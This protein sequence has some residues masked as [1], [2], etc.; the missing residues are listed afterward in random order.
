MLIIHPSACFA[1]FFGPF[2]LEL[3][4]GSF[5]PAAMS[6]LP[7]S[8]ASSHSENRHPRG[9]LRIPLFRCLR[10]QTHR[11]YMYFV[12]RVEIVVRRA[13][14]ARTSK[15]HSTSLFFPHSFSLFLFFPF[16]FFLELQFT[17]I[18]IQTEGLCFL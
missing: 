2:A 3:T 6:P 16:F 7:A 13:G 5:I 18:T 12:I 15:A 14:G 9:I 17:C 8:Y 1:I 4:G 11:V 10:T